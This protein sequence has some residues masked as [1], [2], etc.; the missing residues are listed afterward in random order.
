MHASHCMYW[1]NRVDPTDRHRV[2]E[3]DAAQ[4][5]PRPR[6]RDGVPLCADPAG[7]EG[8]RC[9]ARAPQVA[10][11]MRI[12]RRTTVLLLFAGVAVGV[13]CGG[14]VAGNGGPPSGGQPSTSP[15]TTVTSTSPTATSTPTATTTLPPS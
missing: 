8:L 12:S 13:A 14:Q 4:E 3:A 1:I 15:T 2:D 6:R 5:R 10:L 7:L 11:I 9:R